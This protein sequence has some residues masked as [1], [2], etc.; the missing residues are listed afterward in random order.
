MRKYYN[1]ETMFRILKDE[2]VAFLKKSDIRYE[3]FV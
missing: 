3:L 2:L 1:F